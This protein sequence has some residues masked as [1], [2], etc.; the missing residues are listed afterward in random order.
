MLVAS[1]VAHL[2]AFQ[3]QHVESINP[4]LHENDFNLGTDG[5]LVHGCLYGNSSQLPFCDTSLDVDTRVK[6]L[7]GRLE[8]AEK[9]CLSIS[10]PS[11]GVPRLG[12]PSFVL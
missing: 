3:L 4:Q 1:L 9:V 12:L 5:K 8:L 2:A 7:V 10:S 6:D 11:C